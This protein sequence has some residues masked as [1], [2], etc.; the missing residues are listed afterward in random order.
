MAN[1][2]VK[3]N[4]SEEQK[5]KILD[6]GNQIKYLPNF[7]D[8]VRQ[9]PDVYIGPLS[10][11][12]FLTLAREVFQNGTD[13]M[14][15][16]DSPCT[17]VVI[18]FDERTKWVIVEDN[19]RG[20]PHG[21]LTSIIAEDHTSS[22][23]EKKLF[24]Y[25]AGK[26][27]MGIGIVNALSSELYV[28]SSILGTT[29]RVEFNEGIPW[30]K[31]E[32][33]VKSNKY[34]GSVVSFRPCI[35][36]L[37]DITA[38]WAEIFYLVSLIVPTLKIGAMVYFNAIDMNG[39]EHHEVFVN[40]DGILT[41]LVNICQK[42]MTAPICVF[43][44]TGEMRV[45]LMFTYDI[46]DTDNCNIVSFNNFCPTSKG[47][48]VQGMIEGIQNFFRG[49]INKIFLSGKKLQVINADILC[50]LRGVVHSAL[51][52][53]HYDG[54]NKD[55]LTNL[56]MTPFIATEVYNTLV[57][58]AKKNPK[59]LTKICK[60]I[61]DMAEARIKADTVKI[62]ISNNYKKSVVGGNLPAGYNRPTGK[63]DGHW[64]VF[65]V[66]GDSAGGAALKAC[67]R[68]HQGVFS[69]RGKFP[70]AMSKT[71]E[72]ILNNVEASSIIS[73]LDEGRG[74][75][76]VGNP[77]HKFDLS[78]CPYEKVIAA[79]DADVD[80]VGHIR[81]LILKFF[82]VYLTPIVED[83]R[84][85]ATQPP[86]YMAQIGKKSI[87]FSDEIELSKYINKEFC[88]HNVIEDLN[89]RKLSQ[90]EI[91]SLV[92]RNMQYTTLLD[93]ISKSFAVNI[94][95]LECIL[96]HYDLGFNKLKDVIEK[97]WRFLKVSTVNGT[98]LIS[99]TIDKN[100]TVP[101]NDKL[102]GACGEI[103]N[104]IKKSD[105][106]YKINGKA[107]GLYDTLSTFEKL[108]PSN[109]QRFKGLG[110][111]EAQQLMESTIHPKY[112]RTLI[113]Y[114][115]E[116]IKKE[117]AEIRKIESDFSVLLRDIRGISKNDLV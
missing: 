98:M 42:P 28:E 31:G 112:D 114:T 113:R 10:N 65:I 105:Y 62:K 2:K 37:G 11:I 89:G 39:M 6:Y 58:W 26:N 107:M 83:G 88:K 69:I 15:K 30:D 1:R 3:E 115:V 43:K 50:G 38:T 61:K 109:I 64:E 81:P 55:E 106:G 18:T 100:Q 24:Q 73:I 8:K 19:G 102:I 76:Y 93:N 92:L 5:Q 74:I 49:Y 104:L 96:N 29:H 44:D 101:V 47:T 57:E 16:E 99:G 66:E 36:V 97:R 46:E 108:K 67:D 33:E 53:P 75:N 60:W 70:N 40:E 17:N 41:H 22:N 32:I 45:D 80:G 90:Q 85:Y 12:G 116:D 77:N 13:E 4:F 72:K 21:Q 7:V 79:T 9:T 91:A 35:N 23:Y 117:I 14:Q 51:L 86:L 34:Q 20:F 87:Y 111:M 27:G 82:L 59:D 110:E 71:K 68:F 52:K 95:L 84:F 63:N 103:I 48:H 78:L 56:P 94:Y 54:Q 25:T